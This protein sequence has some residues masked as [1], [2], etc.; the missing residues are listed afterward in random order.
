[1]AENLDKIQQYFGENLDLEISPTRWAPGAR[2]PAYLRHAY[3]FYETEILGVPCLLM[4]DRAKDA[5]SAATVRKHAEQVRSK[6]DGEIIYV[7]DQVVAYQRRRL[8][9]Q[10]V[11]FVVP[12]NQMYLPMLGIDFREHF[13]QI[14]QAASNLMP[15]TQAVLIHVLNHDIE[16]VFTPI[17]LADQLGYAKM[18]MTR[19]FNELEA[20]GL[21]DISMEGRQRCLRF[22]VDRRG[23]WKES[24]PLLR[25]P[26]KQRHHVRTIVP[27]SV[28]AT[29]G[30]SALAKYSMLAAPPI[31]VIAVS[32]QQ[33]KSLQEEMNLS[34]A[35]VDDPESLEIEV[36]TYDP[37]LFSSDGTVDRLSLFLSLRDSEDERVEAALEEMMEAVAW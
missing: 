34:R 33:W 4:A 23:L 28:G 9:E 1:M 2:L 11:P 22:R 14:H 8:V 27:T 13:R 18:T 26:V 36:W 21:G 31:S 3:T 24:Q 30:L 10:N 20:A 37:Q 6:W 7:R 19:A 35:A 25:S 16:A 17:E 29:A 15:A 12:G 5:P 32:L